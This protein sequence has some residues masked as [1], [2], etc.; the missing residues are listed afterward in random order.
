MILTVNMKAKNIKVKLF[1]VGSLTIHT[2]KIYTKTNS[3]LNKNYDICFVNK[4]IFDN[5]EK[6][7]YKTAK[8]SL[9]LLNF[10]SKYINKYNKKILIQTK[11]YFNEAEKLFIEKLFYGCRYK[12]SWRDRVNLNSYKS[13]C[14][15]ELVIGAPSTLLRE[16]SIYPKTKIVCFDPEI[17]FGKLP[18]RGINVIKDNSYEKFEEKLNLLFKLIEEYINKLENKTEYLIEQI[19][20]ITF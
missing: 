16:A 6:N 12:I 11:S 9:V 20:L 2:L 10:L 14:L 5:G 3:N 4:I 7:T 1:P 15:S 19:Q 13:I 17:K 8:D 18:F